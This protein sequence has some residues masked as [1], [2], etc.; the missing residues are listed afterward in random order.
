MTGNDVTTCIEN[1]APLGSI[2]AAALLS[3]SLLTG[4][5]GEPGVDTTAAD[6]A[7][8][9]AMSNARA[10]AFAEGDAAGIAIHFT[11]DAYLMAPD[12]PTRQGRAAVE[13][14]Y[15]SIFDEY[16]TGLESHYDEVD[17]SGSLAYGRGFATVTLTPKAGGQPQTTTAKYLNIL[18][19]QPDGTWKTTHDIWNGN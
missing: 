8:I 16:L 5:C 13:A 4:G 2:G 3:L 1:S 18:K 14:Y 9:A 17:V 15:Q 6:K 7:A 11:D 19:K 10:H 12:T